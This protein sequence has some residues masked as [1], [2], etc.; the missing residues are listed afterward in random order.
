MKITV[1]EDICLGFSHCGSVS[2]T[3]KGEFDMPDEY[4]E[5]LVA[6]IRERGTADIEELQLAELHPEIY[7]FLNKNLNEIYNIAEEAHFIR[8][9]FYMD[10]CYEYDDEFIA[11][12]ESECGFVYS[13]GNDTKEFRNISGSSKFKYITCFLNWLCEYVDT[14]TDQELIDFFYE[15]INNGFNY[16]P[17]EYEIE[18][19]QQIIDL[20]HESGE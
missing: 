19:P 16:S 4:V 7:E 10:D 9:G 1:N 18:I 12:C 11:Y 13:E 17:S 6:L 15:H 20:V 8:R 3:A 5:T 2:A 14:L